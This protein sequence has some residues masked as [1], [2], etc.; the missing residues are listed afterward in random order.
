MIHLSRENA[1]HAFAGL[2]FQTAEL[3]QCR[4]ISTGAAIRTLTSLNA[5]GMFA[6]LRPRAIDLFNHALPED[7]KLTKLQDLYERK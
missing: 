3:Y 7:M 5:L 2:A 4:E 1:E 6:G